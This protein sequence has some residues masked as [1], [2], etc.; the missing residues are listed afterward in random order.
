[1]ILLYDDKEDML[2]E[3]NIENLVN[4]VIGILFKF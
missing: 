2:K 1:M 4:W 3:N